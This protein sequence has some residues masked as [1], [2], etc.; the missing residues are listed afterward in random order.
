MRQIRTITV[1]NVLECFL[2]LGVVSVAATSPYFLYRLMRLLFKS[3]NYGK[4][5]KNK[6]R[7]AFYYAKKNGFIEI[8][9]DDHDI[10]IFI[11][12]KG[13]TWMKK[14][15]I[16]NLEITKPKKWDGKFRIIAFDIPNIQRIKRNAF[17][18]KLKELGFYSTQKSVWLHPYD[19][20]EEI[21]ILMNF[22]GLTNKQIQIFVA[23][24]IY[25]DILSEKIKNVY[26]I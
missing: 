9:K 22:F 16:A 1:K 12:E 14:Y 2:L 19:C 18:A 13:K 8:E 4:I 17:R 26:K 23:E 3:D 25:D 24:K 20:Q 7:S 11:T 21:K 5:H 10:K 6:F 15:K